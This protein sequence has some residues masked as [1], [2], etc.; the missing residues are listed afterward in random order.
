M[1]AGAVAMMAEAA[2][3]RDDV[4][5]VAAVVAGHAAGWL[6]GPATFFL[7]AQVSILLHLVCMI[8]EFVLAAQISILLRLV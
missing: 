3:E 7:A 5:V 2:E 4:A 6:A 1:A 8:C